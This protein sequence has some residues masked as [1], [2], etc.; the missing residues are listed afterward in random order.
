MGIESRTWLP[1]AKERELTTKGHRASSGGERIVLGSGFMTAY[2]WWILLH[3]N[4]TSM[5][6]D[7]FFPPRHTQLV[8]S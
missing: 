5:K 7:F 2:I 3:T 8:Q 6:S 1:E 4:Y